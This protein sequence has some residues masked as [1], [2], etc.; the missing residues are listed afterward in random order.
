[1]IRQ[2]GTLWAQTILFVDLFLYGA[3]RVMVEEA[4]SQ[5]LTLYPRLA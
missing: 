2:M 1:M 5:D 4:L 3:L